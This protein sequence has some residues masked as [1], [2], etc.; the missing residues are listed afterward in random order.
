MFPPSP[1]VSSSSGDRAR[2]R[3]DRILMQL[4]EIDWENK[5]A[6]EYVSTMVA[7]PELGLPD[8]FDETKG[9]CAI[10]RHRQLYGIDTHAIKVCDECIPV[11]CLKGTCCGFAY[12][13]IPF[14]AA[15]CSCADEMINISKHVIVDVG[16]K[17]VKARG[18][19]LEMCLAIL[20][21]F[22]GTAKCR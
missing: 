3:A 1:M 2:R 7:I 16:K 18:D 13:A 6:L 12:V 4:R 22:T 9:G 14:D 10:W 15:S 21:I 20:A 17:V 5:T 11:Q 8:V 19:S